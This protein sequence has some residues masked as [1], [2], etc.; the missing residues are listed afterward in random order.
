M[1]TIDPKV[2]RETITRE[3]ADAWRTL[4]KRHPDERF[5]S[6]GVY[7]T[8]LADYLMVTAGTEEG[9]TVVTNRYLAQKASDPFLMRASLRWSPCDSPLHA[10]GMSLLPE[11]DRLRTAGPD[12][13][14][15]SEESDAAIAF[16]FATI[17]DA[18]Q[19][20]DRCGLLAPMRVEQT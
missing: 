1:A 17:V 6:F 5:Y 15:G 11:S 20:L 19:E 16:V 2:F 9:L 3:L 12:P 14:E 7:T 10:E 4:T 8:E 18:L 13:Y